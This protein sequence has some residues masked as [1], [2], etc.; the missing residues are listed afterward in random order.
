MR[1]SW[2]RRFHAGEQKK[3]F[4]IPYPPVTQLE[5]MNRAVQAERAL[6]RASEPARLASV[7]LDLRLPLAR[8]AAS[9]PGSG[10]DEARR[11]EGRFVLTGYRSWH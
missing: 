5:T 11:L 4:L 2:D 10:I 9:E 6:I 3:G 7:R 8:R 1:A